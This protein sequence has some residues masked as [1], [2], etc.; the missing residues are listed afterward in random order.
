[1]GSVYRRRVPR[2]ELWRDHPAR[3]ELQALYTRVDELVRESRCS[4][5]TA[6]GPEDA[7]CCQ[8]GMTGREPYPT[9][10]E[11]CEVEH[12]RRSL[13]TPRADSRAGRR[14]LPVAGRN[15]A[16]CPLLSPLGRCTIYAS[17]PFG[18]RTYFCRGHEPP[19]VVREAIQA[20][21]RLLG[22]L[23]DRYFPRDPLPRPFTR[24]L[25]GP[26]PVVPPRSRRPG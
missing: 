11:L 6:T 20:E 4:C 19:R 1:M 18:C 25:A 16:A 5:A 8:F 17:R 9:P 13:G 7:R 12:A 14:R 15:Q 3:D 2:K 21:G 23:A 26:S 24:A 22:A 10:I